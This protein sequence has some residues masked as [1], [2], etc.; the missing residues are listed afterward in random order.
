M[1]L[2]RVLMVSYEPSCFT[3]INGSS[4]LEFNAH[5]NNDPSHI[6]YTIYDAPALSHSLS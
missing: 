3:I 4:M 6:L 1:F 5:I 2:N